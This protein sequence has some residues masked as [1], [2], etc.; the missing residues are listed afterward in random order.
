MK[1]LSS[2]PVRSAAIVYRRTKLC[3][4]QYYFQYYLIKYNSLI[5]LIFNLFV[6]VELLLVQIISGAYL[7]RLRQHYHRINTF[8][9][10]FNFMSTEEKQTE[11]INSETVKQVC[12]AARPSHTVVKTN[13]IVHI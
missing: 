6:N 12:M 10:S 8:S 13:I 4:I 2:S 1:D 5:L 9:I 3:E 11:N 7:F